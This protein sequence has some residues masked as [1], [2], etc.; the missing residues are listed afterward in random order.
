MQ[1]SL[2]IRIDR[3]GRIFFAIP[4]PTTVVRKYKNLAVDV[5]YDCFR[6]CVDVDDEVALPLA[7]KS[8]DDARSAVSV[9]ANQVVVRLLELERNAQG[10]PIA[11]RDVR[12]VPPASLNITPASGIV[13]AVRGDAGRSDQQL[14]TFAELFE[15]WALQHV[16]TGGAP[17][18]PPYWRV[19]IQRF[20]AFLGHDRPQD[21]TAHDIRAYRDHLIATGRRLRTA[22]HS[23]FAALRALFQFAVENEFVTGNPTTGIRFKPERL[24]A[25]QAMKA[26]SPVQARGILAAADKETLAARRWIPWLTALTGSRVAAIANLR[27]QDVV[28]VEGIWCLRISRQAGPIKTAASERLVPIHSAVLAR[29]FLSFVE[30][31]DRE[32]LF[33]EKPLA[34]NGLQLMITA[35]TG[36]R[37][38]HPARSTLRRL[39]DWLHSLDLGIGRDAKVDPNHAWRHWFKEQAF[40]EGVPE[41]ITDAIVG[42]AQ[43]TTSRRY[44]SVSMV[45]MAEALEKI[46]PPV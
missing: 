5:V 29:G 27:K 34:V 17:T 2:D 38:Y 26:F 14:L 41:K 32:R 1:P 15:V 35:E 24:A 37:V 12:L 7:S 44:G 23:D 10:V 6:F 40:A 9:V 43:A 18:T 46:R 42:H 39:S 30:K 22:R 13:T 19:L 31:T 3:E 8:F 21:V 45:M 16:Q 25:A 20:V 4:L 36:P 33:I 28:Q 11:A